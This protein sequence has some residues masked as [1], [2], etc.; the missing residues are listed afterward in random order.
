MSIRSPLPPYEY[1]YQTILQ[2]SPMT[3][4]TRKVPEHYTAAGLTDRIVL[5]S[6]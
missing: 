4:T 5:Q 1:S 3:D 2:E 6:P